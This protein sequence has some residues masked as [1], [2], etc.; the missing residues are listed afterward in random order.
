MARQARF[1]APEPLHIFQ[2]EFYDHAAPPTISHAPMPQASK[3][4]RQ[5][6]QSTNANVVLN[7]PSTTFI[8]QSPFKSNARSSNA[9]LTP[10]KAS[11]GNKLNMVPMMPPSNFQQST[12]SLEKKQPLMSRFKTVAQKPTPP[13]MGMQFMGKENSHPPIFPAPMPPQFNIPLENYYQKPSGKRVLL[14]AA[15]IKELRP[16]KK[17]RLEEPL[18]TPDSFPSIVDDGAKPGHSY[19]TLIGMAILRSPQRRLTL[20][21]IYKWISDTF[22]FYNAND[23]GWQNSIRHNLSLNKH[24]IKQ[25]RPKDDPGKGNYWAIEPGAEHLFI[26]E[27]PS[28]K[29]ASTAENLPVMSTRLEP[30]Q[31]HMSFIQEPILPPQLPMSQSSLSALP[32]MPQPSQHTNAPLPEISSDATIPVSDMATLDDIP[33]RQNEAET[34]NEADLYPNLPAAMHS[35][36]PVPRHMDAL[37]SGTPPPPLQLHNSSAT[38]SRSRKRRFTSMDDS[39]YISSLESSVMRPNQHAKLLTSEADRPRIKRGR[40]EEEIARLRASS[41]DSPSKGR[42]FGYH[43]ASSSPLRQTSNSGQGQMLP[44]LT[45][46][47][48]LKAPPKPPPSVSPSTNL[49]LHRESIQSM[50]DSPYKRVNALLP[51]GD[52]LLQLTPGFSVDEVFYGYDRKSEEHLDLDIFQDSPYASIFTVTPAA[53]RNGSPTKKSAKRQ[54]MDRSLSTSALHD[55]SNFG[56]SHNFTDSFLKVPAPSANLM[57]DTPSKMFDNLPS[58]PSKLFMTSPSKMPEINDENVAPF[59]SLDDLCAPDFLEDSDF[60]GIDMLAGFEKIGS[61]NAQASSSRGTKPS[62]KAPLSR[63]YTS[64]F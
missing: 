4:H 44:P 29:A 10:L 43:P 45:P 19:A 6:L 61:N 41:Y 52:N 12:D 58:S 60:A 24:F 31:P 20:A 17:P 18:P 51:E 48:K 21:Q 11:Q 57:F 30:S 8:K 3:P 59:F 22:S 40:A 2:D 1:A 38:K 47:M 62:Q 55:M 35:S 15:P 23:A 13:E 56:G 14:E 50:M 9:P 49:R 36:P 46:A 26:K 64:N 53:V 5:P 33:E 39:G 27:K 54:R 7:P 16:A 25:E 63:C 37:H 42:P 32:P 28:R 34:V